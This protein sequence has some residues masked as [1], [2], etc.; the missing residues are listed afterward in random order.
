MNSLNIGICQLKIN[1]QSLIPKNKNQ[2]LTSDM[3]DYTGGASLEKY[4]FFSEV[5]KYPRKDLQKLSYNKN[6]YSIEYYV[7]KESFKS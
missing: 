6:T 7:S 2:P 5:H 1:I 3:L 4:P